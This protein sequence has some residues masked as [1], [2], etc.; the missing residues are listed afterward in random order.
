MSMGL[1]KDLF[2]KKF[3]LG[4][5]ITEPFQ[6]NKSFVRELS[7]SDFYQYSKNTRPF[8]SIGISFGYRFGK[9][10][11]NERDRRKDNNDMREEEQGN[12]N[13]MRG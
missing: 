6:E 5:S 1:K 7:G 13:Q 10:D 2:N 11:F 3:T 9:L 12:D 8:R 4:L